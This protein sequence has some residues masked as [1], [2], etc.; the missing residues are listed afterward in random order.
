MR[1]EKSEDSSIFVG[2]TMDTTCNWSDTNTGRRYSN[3]RGWYVA[4]L[5]GYLT[6]SLLGEDADRPESIHWHF[7]ATTKIL[8]SL[9]SI[10]TVST[11]YDRGNHE[12]RFKIDDQEIGL[13]FS[14]VYEQRLIPALHL[15]CAHTITLIDQ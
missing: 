10:V 9:H 2:F 3:V 11:T 6:I 12:I 1:I 14:N 7:S 8:G 5:E 15:W 4:P 13:C